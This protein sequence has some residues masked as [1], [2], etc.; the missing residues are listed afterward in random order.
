MIYFM[1]SKVKKVFSCCVN[2]FLA[3]EHLVL[4]SNA[5]ARPWSFRILCQSELETTALSVIRTF[6]SSYDEIF[7]I[8]GV[9]DNNSN[10]N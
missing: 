1:S 4:S 3:Q 9:T 5:I 7:N 8:G 6:L 2:L 10:N